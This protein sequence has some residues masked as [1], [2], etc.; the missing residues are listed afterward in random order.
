MN[1]RSQL[2]SHLLSVICY[3]LS[4]IGASAHVAGNALAAEV[5]AGVVVSLTPEE[6][7]PVLPNG[8]PLELLPVDPAKIKKAPKLPQTT[9]G[10]IGAYAAAPGISYYQ[11][12]G[13]Y[14]TQAGGTEIVEGSVTTT[15]YDHGGSQMYVY[16]YQHGYGTQYPVTLNGIA[17]NP[18][19][20]YLV[21]G[22]LATRHTPC[23]ENK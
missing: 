18:D 3:L 19:E 11:I 2:V 23:V 9:D 12:Y 17:R 22:T 1:R 20:T 10:T 21:C 8:E 13:V 16:V 14:S 7:N 5:E 4:A 6:Q 15:S